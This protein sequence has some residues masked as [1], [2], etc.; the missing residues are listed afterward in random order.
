MGRIGIN[1]DDWFGGGGCAKVLKKG[2]EG[3]ES[4]RRK[5]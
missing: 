4:E 3:E 5:V 2:L 1:M